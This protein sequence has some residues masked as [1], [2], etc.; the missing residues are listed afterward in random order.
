MIKEYSLKRKTAILLSL[1][2]LISSLSVTFYNSLKSIEESSSQSD[3]VAE[4][5]ETSVQAENNS[6]TDEL[7]HYFLDNIRKAAHLIEFATLG[8]A[9]SLLIISAKLSEFKYII[10]AFFFSLSC[11]VI[12]EG[13][14]VISNRGSLV[15]DILIDCL[16]S[17]FTVAIVL[18]IYYLI[19][20]LY[21]KKHEV[22]NEN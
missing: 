4:R 9:L 6:K 10:Y 17:W 5:I 21:S 15:T 2:L 1:L 11:A 19:K 16:G 13:L 22:Q 20:K 12:D 3:A 14:Q 8:L 18:L 7:L